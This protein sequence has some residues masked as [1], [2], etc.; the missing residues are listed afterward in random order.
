MFK[1]TLKS[2]VTCLLASFLLG[3]PIWT[4]QTDVPDSTLSFLEPSTNTSCHSA[5]MSCTGSA[6]PWEFLPQHRHPTPMNCAVSLT[7]LSLQTMSLGCHTSVPSSLLR[8]V[9]NHDM[10]RQAGRVHCG[11]RDGRHGYGLG[12]GAYQH[13]PTHIPIRSSSHSYDTHSLQVTVIVSHGLPVRCKHAQTCPATTEISRCSRHH[14]AYIPI[15]QYVLYAH[16]PSAVT[17]AGLSYTVRR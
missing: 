1:R 16:R 2:L 7:R 11:P 4:M 12:I 5:N 13:S 3:P 14:Q 9:S 10:T 15:P 17:P 6:S 8:S